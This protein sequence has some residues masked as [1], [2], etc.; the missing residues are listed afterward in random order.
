[1]L[2]M[3]GLAFLFGCFVSFSGENEEK[4]EKDYGMNEEQNN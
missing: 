3:F 2:E 4:Y 1:M